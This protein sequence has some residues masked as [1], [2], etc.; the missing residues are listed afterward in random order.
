MKDYLEYSMGGGKPKKC[1]TI[2]WK[3]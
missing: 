2:S 3:W 1:K